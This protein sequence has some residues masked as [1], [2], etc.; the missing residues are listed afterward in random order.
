[1]GFQI[2][3]G[4]QIREIDLTTIVPT[5]AS[6]AAGMAGVFRWGPCHTRVLVDSEN[7]LRE[8]F[9][10]PDNDTASFFFTAANF[11]GYG[12]NLQVVRVIG[13]GAVNATP[14]G[15]AAFTIENEEDYE[16]TANQTNLETAAFIAKYPGVLGNSL[17][18][19]VQDGS[20][21]HTFAI[22]GSAAAG[23]TTVNV[24]EPNGGAGRIYVEDGDF[25]E[26]DYGSPIGSSVYTISTD[27]RGTTW[28]AGSSGSI[29]IDEPLSRALSGGET[30]TV[31]HRFS[32]IFSKAATTTSSV[33]A[34]GGS[35]DEIHIAVIDKNGLWTGIR[36]SVLETFQSVSKSPN[37]VRANGENIYYQNVV[38]RQS[39]YIWAGVSGAHLSS[40]ANGDN[41]TTY[42]TLT[43]TKG[44]TYAGGWGGTGDAGQA[45]YA[46]LSGGADGVL[47]TNAAELWDRGYS[48]FEDAQTVD[49]SLIL[50]GP[51]N[52]TTQK[53]IIDMCDKRKD[54]IA[55]LSPV[56]D[57]YGSEYTIVKDKTLNEQTRD[58]VAF[59][60]TTL[61]KSSSYAVL[62]SGYKYMY[63]RYNDVYRH[64]PLNGDIAGLCARTEQDA[65]AWYSPAGFNRG[66]IRG[67]VKLPF[68]P[69]QTHRDDL[70]K[71]EVNPVVAFPGEGVI[72]YGDKT[73]QSKPSAFDRINVRRLFII[74]EKAI[75]TA[76]KFSLFEFNDEFTR[77]QFRNLII[78]FLRDVQSRRGIFDFKVVC[79]ASNNTDS[80]VNRNEFVA[81]IY[82]KPTRSINFI[83]LNFIATANGVDFNEV[84]A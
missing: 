15:I 68:N 24:R 80:V 59:R 8:T 30:A 52:S 70:Y 32:R 62:D 20:G 37:A 17:A 38:N 11:L 57:T 53:L 28:A 43:T 19:Y 36:N 72:L 27:N 64:V 76:A 48:L 75:A 16:A 58:V 69:K 31:K 18:V 35:N 3:P 33:D 26:I 40:Q 74:L 41:T 60:N 13:S 25:L 22:T 54:C 9:G 29:N 79:D 73:L 51:S 6:T 45:Y 78:P 47:A 10:K 39:Q 7:T 67:V 55:F 65:E 77:N 34:L 4:V 46:V 2:S 12:N 23:A 56:S 1:M 81:D 71:N 5:I 63:D 66:Q 83:Q 42:S 84:G 21:E 61:N 14:E 44:N 49:V 50:G 82:I